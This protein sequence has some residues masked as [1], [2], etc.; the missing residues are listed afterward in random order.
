MTDPSVDGEKNEHLRRM[1]LI[2]ARERARE[3]G[4][5]RRST[6]STPTRAARRWRATSTRSASVYFYWLLG[7]RSRHYEACPKSPDVDRRL[8]DGS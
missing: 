3:T 1:A 6:G 2:E 4:C 5:V 8:T 7:F